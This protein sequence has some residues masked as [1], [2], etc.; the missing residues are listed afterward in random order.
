MARAKRV[1]PAFDDKVLADWNGMMIA[2][3]V[4][5]G[6]VFKKADW[7]FAAIR[8]FWAIAEMLGDGNKLYHSFREKRG[9]DETTADGYAN[10]ARA[11]LLLYEFSA[12]M[13]YLDKAK[14]W[15]E[16]LDTAFADTERG[17]YYYSSID[18]G[19]VIIRVKTAVELQT[20]NY[21]GIITEVL[22]RL[23]FLTGDQSFR[24]RC[25]ATIAAA[26]PEIEKQS[27]GCATM[28]NAMEFTVNAVQIVILGDD[29]SAETQALV[30]AV[31]DRSVATRIL[32]L[33]RPGQKLP[34]NHPAFGKAMEGGKATA[35]VCVG[36]TCSP[37]ITQPAQL[38]NGLLA[39]PFIQIM[40]AQQQRQQQAQQGQ[41]PG[42]PP[43][44]NLR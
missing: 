36:Q 7:H 26:G 5:A 23:Y 19:D 33:M 15:V 22:A 32:L 28:L 24:E 44:A 8:A 27:L 13:R 6:A 35:Y 39:P 38:S 40:Q 16:R 14:E 30:R 2:A 18:A 4:Q 9:R 25:V 29:R 41:P 12:D 10:M 11:A 20:G 3:L 21:N 37:P 42:R 31:L 17:G 34:A 43:A 1:R